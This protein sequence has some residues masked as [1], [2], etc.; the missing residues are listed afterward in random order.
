MIV[1]LWSVLHTN[2]VTCLLICCIRE[3]ST[4]GEQLPASKRSIAI[5]F[6]RSLSLRTATKPDTVPHPPPAGQDCKQQW[7]ERILHMSFF[8]VYFLIP[9]CAHHNSLQTWQTHSFR[10]IFFSLSLKRNFLAF[11]QNFCIYAWCLWHAS[12]LLARNCEVSLFLWWFEWGTKK[13]REN[14]Q[15]AG[16]LYNSFSWLTNYFLDQSTSS[17]LKDLFWFCFIID[18]ELTN[19]FF[20]PWFF[21]GK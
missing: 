13:K 14:R 1:D 4:S 6:K 15:L 3:L 2:T 5:R 18:N 19:P 12:F 16:F 21:A 11:E 8:F 20:P 7:L 17:V 9:P 10:L